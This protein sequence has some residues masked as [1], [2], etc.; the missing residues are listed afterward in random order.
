[1]TVEERQEF[2]DLPDEPPANL[3]YGEEFFPALPDISD[4]EQDRTGRIYGMSYC[5][6]NGS[7]KNTI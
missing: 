3:V 7:T 4:D 6:G 2:L 5:L 1:M